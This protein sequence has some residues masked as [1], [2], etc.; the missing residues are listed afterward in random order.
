M[1]LPVKGITMVLVGYLAVSGQTADWPQFR[2]PTG[3][4]VTQ[5]TSLPSEWAADKG[6]KWKAKIPGYAWSC[7]VVWGDKVF[8]TTAVSEKQTKPSMRGGFGGG[9]FGGG[10]GGGFGGRRSGP[11]DDIYRWEVYCLDRADGKVLWKQLAIER[12]P[13]IAT[14]NT[15]TYASETPVTDGERL[16][17]YFGMTGVFCFDFTGKQLWTK[18]LGSYRMM[19]GWGTGSSPTLEGDRLFV[20]CDNEEKSF[21]VALTKKTG[22]Q[23]WR[24]ERDE[25]SSWSTPYVWKNQKRTELV[26][27]GSRKV[28][29]Y[30]PATGKVLWEVGGLSGRCAATPVGD[31]DM[32]YFGSGGGQG[33]RGFGGGGGGGGGGMGGGGGPLFAVRAGTSGDVSLKSG[34][35]SNA[36]IAWSATSGGPSTAS[37]LLYKGHLYILGNGMLTCFDAKTGKPAYSKERL[38]NARGFTS[39]PWAYEGKIFCLDEAGL[40]TVIQAGPEFKV[41]GKNKLDDM[42]W[43]SPAIAG[44]TLFIRGLDN[45]YCIKP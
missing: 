11:P 39:S 21:L 37:P 12:K 14:H 30:D 24:V 3:D 26:V 35:T 31:A 22:E 40:T 45:V 5:E 42:F 29:S 7:P 2:G 43:S 25:R 23:L 1:R 41:L 10:G 27:S 6:I 44:G 13:T 16:Y 28:R 20:Q 32:I 38:P 4:G 15:N 19:M 18:D 36:G 33:G 8:L 9:G 17:A 34:E